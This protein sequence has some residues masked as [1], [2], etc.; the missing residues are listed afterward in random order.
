MSS[1]N[2]QVSHEQHEVQLH[3]TGM[4]CASCAAHVEK[5]LNQIDGVDASVNYATERA[6]VYSLDELDFFCSHLIP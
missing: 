4:T 2:D 6:T 3:I 5:A 1:V